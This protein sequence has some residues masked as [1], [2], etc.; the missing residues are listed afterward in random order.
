MENIIDSIQ[1]TNEEIVT[2]INWF[3]KKERDLVKSKHEV[4][5]EYAHL[6]EFKFAA[7]NNRIICAFD[8]VSEIIDRK[9][10]YE[11]VGIYNINFRV[12]DGGSIEEGSFIENQRCLV[13]KNLF[14]K[15]TPEMEAE[16]N[17]EYDHNYDAL[18][19]KEREHWKRIIKE[20]HQML[21]LLK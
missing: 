11:I 18:K 21:E 3:N 13:H 8:S 9:D 4:R 6:N 1:L 17:D 12:L 10:C 7:K 15:A 5:R 16:L 19:V 20:A 2:R 14:A